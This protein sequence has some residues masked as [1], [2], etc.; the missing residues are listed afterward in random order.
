MATCV[1]A[2]INVHRSISEDMAR[3]AQDLIRSRHT[4]G[5]PTRLII[6]SIARLVLNA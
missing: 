1:D 6:D 4:H 5:H 2:V 3:A